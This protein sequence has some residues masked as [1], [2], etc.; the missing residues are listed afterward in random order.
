MTLGTI[1]RYAVM[2]ISIDRCITDSD[3]TEKLDQIMGFVLDCPDLADLDL[4]LLDKRS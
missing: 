1:L 2:G 4:D 3:R